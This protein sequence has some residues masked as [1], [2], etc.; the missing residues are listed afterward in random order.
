MCGKFTAL[1]VGV[2]TLYKTI[3]FLIASGLRECVRSER[4][5]ANCY[6]TQDLHC[7]TVM[8]I[9]S[10]LVAWIFDGF[11]FLFL[12][13]LIILFGLNAENSQIKIFNFSLSLNVL[14]LAAAELSANVCVAHGT[15]CN[16]PSV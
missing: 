8:V 12:F 14:P 4:S 9:D 2:K 13:C 11:L 10:A 6:Y 15:L 1:R 5:C 16:D 7:T 3:S